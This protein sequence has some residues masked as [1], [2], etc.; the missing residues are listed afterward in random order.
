MTPR[1]VKIGEAN[2]GWLTVKERAAVSHVSMRL[3]SI[4]SPAKGSI[5]LQ[6]LDTGPFPQ[7]EGTGEMCGEQFN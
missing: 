6:K 4:S 1:R 3:M 7:F 2:V 5:S